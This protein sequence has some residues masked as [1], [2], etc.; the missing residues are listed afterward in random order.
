M[1]LLELKNIS[2]SFKDGNARMNH[3]LRQL[4]FEVEQ[5]D[6]VAVRGQSGAGKTTLLNVL[7]TLLLPDSGTYVLEG[8][9]LLEDNVDLASV[10]NK[11]IG[12]VFQDHRLL[13]Q[14]NVLQNILLPLM[15]A[16]NE[17]S[18][19][20]IKWARQL[21]EL[22]NIAPLENQFP[23]TLSGG[24][25]CRVAVCRALINKPVVLLADE[26]TG[27]LDKDNAQHIASLFQLVNKELQTTI[28]MVTH[29]DQ[30][31]NAAKRIVT[32]IDGV[33]VKEK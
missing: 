12:F 26:P 31:A 18:E 19:E 33:L 21:M 2:K 7:G 10:R 9:S 17:V 28:V 1:A 32:L 8:Q 16:A 23:L 5:G 3:V 24:E 29:S 13:P 30:T 6:F 22:T 20:Q 14:Y 15:A 11:K 4:C 27:Q 25:A